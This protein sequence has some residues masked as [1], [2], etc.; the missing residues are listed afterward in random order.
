MGR[1]RLFETTDP[2][3]QQRAEVSLIKERQKHS[4][5]QGLPVEKGGEGTP[6]Q[7]AGIQAVARAR[8]AALD[9]STKQGVW[10]RWLRFKGWGGDCHGC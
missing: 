6:E 2:K 7:M 4:K 8:S 1:E 3:V 10:E 5:S 9:S